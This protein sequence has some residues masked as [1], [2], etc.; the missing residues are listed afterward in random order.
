MQAQTDIS[1][2]AAVTSGTGFGISM[3]AVTGSIANKGSVISGADVALKA[4]QDIFNEDDIRA[5][6]KGYDGSGKRKRYRQSGR[7]DDC[8]C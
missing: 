5:D 2:S 4:Q 6:A 7:P 8:R 1:N 3:T